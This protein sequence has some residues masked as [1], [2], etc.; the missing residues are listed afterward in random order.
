VSHLMQK[1][2][3][4]RA[5]ILIFEFYSKEN[6][7][8]IR[9]VFPLAINFIHKEFSTLSFYSLTKFSSFFY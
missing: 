9:K 7:N 5:S 6:C 8:F 2:E 4:D 1:V 3:E